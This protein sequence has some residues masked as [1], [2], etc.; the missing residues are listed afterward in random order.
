MNAANDLTLLVHDLAGLWTEPVLEILK[1]AG[2]HSMSVDIE[3]EVWRTLKKVLNCELRWQR[4]M[5]LSTL[6]SLNAVGEQ[7][8]RKAALLVARRLEPQSVSDAFERQIRQLAAERRSTATE[9][10]LFA[11]IVRQPALHAAFK[12]PSRTDFTPRLRMSA[13]GG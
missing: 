12:P 3:L 9:R 2:I 4:A 5:R 6:V 13:L 8:L 1:A 11:E 7:V 10:R